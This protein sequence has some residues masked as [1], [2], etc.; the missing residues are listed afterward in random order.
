MPQV[1]KESGTE[2]EEEIGDSQ[3]P[4]NKFINFLLVMVRKKKLM[5]NITTFMVRY[6]LF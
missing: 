2:G 6:M 1:E 3:E 5:Y 4:L